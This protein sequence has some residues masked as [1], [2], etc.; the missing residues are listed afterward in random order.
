MMNRAASETESSAYPAANAQSALIARPAA[1]LGRLSQRPSIVTTTCQERASFSFAT[2]RL[3]LRPGSL[4]GQDSAAVRAAADVMKA[5]M[6][7]TTAE[8]ETD[9]Q[10]HCCME[11]DPRPAFGVAQT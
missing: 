7:V 10:I 9:S 11:S 3:G 4:L 1:I 6:A 5:V 8:A 2:T